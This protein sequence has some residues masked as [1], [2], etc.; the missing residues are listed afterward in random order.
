[1]CLSLFLFAKIFQFYI[2]KKKNLENFFSFQNIL[3]FT[4]PML[5]FTKKLKPFA[6][7]QNFGPSYLTPVGRFNFSS[8]IEIDDPIDDEFEV[9]KVEP[10]QQDQDYKK[11][12]F[13]VLFPIKTPLFP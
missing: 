3:H 10:T 12:P 5:S 7:V 6:W 11:Q 13:Y 8:S 2:A 9:F 1:M 4:Q